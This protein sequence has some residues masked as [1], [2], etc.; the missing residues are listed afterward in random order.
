MDPWFAMTAACALLCSYYCRNWARWDVFGLGL[1]L[2]GQAYLRSV[3]ADIDWDYARLPSGNEYT[4]HAL[5]QSFSPW[6]WKFVA[7]RPGEIQIVHLSLLPPV[8]NATVRKIFGYP[9][10]AEYAL[11]LQLGWS[12]LEKFGEGHQR[13]LVF[14]AWSRPEFV[15]FREFARLAWTYRVDI[16]SGERCV[17][18]S[19]LRYVILGFIPSF[20]YGICR[21]VDEFTWRLYRLRRST[22]AE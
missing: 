13:G 15:Q 18:F 5:P 9:E 21:L 7:E 19:D 1:C 8:L 20:R 10:L 12:R 2:I 16:A 22:V 3:V 11:P 14:Q 6:H 4:V 17:W